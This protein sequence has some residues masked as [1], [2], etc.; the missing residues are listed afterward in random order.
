MVFF[1]C[2]VDLFQTEAE[3]SIQ[4]SVISNHGLLPHEGVLIGFRFNLCAIE[5][6]RFF[7][8]LRPLVVRRLIRHKR[9]LRRSLSFQ[10]G[11]G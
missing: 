3:L 2:S 4:F 10:L 11:N 7:R 6:E 1:F 9:L 5:E 8:L